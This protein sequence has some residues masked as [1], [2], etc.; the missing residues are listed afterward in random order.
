MRVRW[1][2]TVSI[3][4]VSARAERRLCSRA[5]CSW[6][7]VSL[8]SRGVFMMLVGPELSHRV[9]VGKRARDRPRKARTSTKGT[10]TQAHA[11][12][13]KRMHGHASAWIRIAHQK[14]RYVTSMSRLPM[15]SV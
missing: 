1:P 7:L 14:C 4:Y 2:L 13:R 15:N 6:A 9:E 11:R 12:P 10:A 5:L 8:L 3:S